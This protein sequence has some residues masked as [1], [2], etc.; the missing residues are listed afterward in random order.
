MLSKLFFLL[1]RKLGYDVTPNNFYSPIPDLREL[2]LEDDVWSKRSKLVGIDINED[3]QMK[4]LQR[5]QLSYKN[6]YDKFPINRTATSHEYFL[7]N[8]VFQCIDAEILY[9]MIRHFKPRRILEVGSG[10]STYLM[11]QAVAKNREQDCQY[12]CDLV[13]I[14]PYPN[15]TLQAG[16]P[17]L[18]RLIDQKVQSV[19]LSEFTALSA[20]DVLFIDSSHVLKTGS[21]VQYEYLEILPRLAKGVIIHIHDIFLPEEYPKGWLLDHHRFWNEQYILQALLSYNDCFKV[22]WMARHMRV[23]HHD[24]LAEAFRSYSSLKAEGATWVGPASFWLKK[25]R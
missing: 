19:P 8:G 15:S 13:A 5:F 4:L 14:D 17:G 1:G 25:I 2:E 22:L 7:K 9:C 18:S 3:G 20:D 24:A 10:N 11:A 12:A 16:F 23:T 6:E 21:D